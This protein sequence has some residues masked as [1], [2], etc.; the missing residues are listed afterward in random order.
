[1][2]SVT[3]TDLARK[4]GI[5][6]WNPNDPNYFYKDSP[7]AQIP[8]IEGIAHLHL[9]IEHMA[10]KGVGDM[11]S[12]SPLHRNSIRAFMERIGV[13]NGL[14]ES[15][16]LRKQ[17]G[18][19]V[20][21]APIHPGVH[22]VRID[23]PIYRRPA[24]DFHNEQNS[25]AQ[26]A[27][28]DE[29]GNM[30]PI[31]HGSM[32]GQTNQ[33][34]QQYV[35]E[36]LANHLASTHRI[37]VTISLQKHLR[38]GATPETM[39]EPHVAFNVHNALHSGVDLSALHDDLKAATP[40]LLHTSGMINGHTGDSTLKIGMHPDA[41]LADM[42]AVKDV[43]HKHIR[44]P[45][46]TM[47][48]M[49]V[50]VVPP[51]RNQGMDAEKAVE[52]NAEP[53]PVEKAEDIDE[54]DEKVAR[55]MRE[56]KK[57]KLKSSSG[58]RVMSRDQALAIALSEA[59]REKALEL[60]QEAVEFMPRPAEWTPEHDDFTVKSLPEYEHDD[61]FRLLH[62]ALIRRWSNE[63]RRAMRETGNG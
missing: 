44:N 58:K 54:A 47:Q 18:P 5:Q 28:G 21:N 20:V 19:H 12:S 53:E 61:D 63:Y 6:L 59:R 23:V 31:G 22:T 49:F 30:S 35:H 14:R 50:G 13:P 9:P 3:L 1:M 17:F 7:L 25:S 32:L 40:H 39:L 55:V 56:F 60:W 41:T 10:Q 16:E 62:K 38:F 52:D 4:L 26:K 45:L 51:S 37:P 57:G 36:A 24:I 34:E 48:N 33:P 43:I 42:Q 8:G 15:P 27:V 2:D 46:V 29:S 11:A